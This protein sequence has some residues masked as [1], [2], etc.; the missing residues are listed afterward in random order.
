MQTTALVDVVAQEPLLNCVR[1]GATLFPSESALRRKRA[2]R[3]IRRRTAVRLFNLLQVLSPKKNE[4]GLA[5]KWLAL[6][7]TLAMV[8]ASSSQEMTGIERIVVSP[9]TPNLSVKLIQ[10]ADDGT[11]F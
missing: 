10:A 1:D 9:R 11:P 6:F 8:G 2:F 7:L 4:R 3:V 5:M